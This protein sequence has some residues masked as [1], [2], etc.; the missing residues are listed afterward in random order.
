MIQGVNNI[1]LPYLI[2]VNI[3]TVDLDAIDTPN[4]CKVLLGMDVSQRAR[5][6]WPTTTSQLTDLDQLQVSF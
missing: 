1:T 2:R 3:T 4:R 5:H 6:R